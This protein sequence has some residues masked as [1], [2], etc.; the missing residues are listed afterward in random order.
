MFKIKK[1]K[2]L[3]I[4]IILS[5]SFL[6]FSKGELATWL[7]KM[8]NPI[9]LIGNYKEGMVDL[10]KLEIEQTGLNYSSRVST[11]GWEISSTF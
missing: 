10:K 9:I 2:S 8:N 11:Y 5:L 1:I 3:S 7:K 6:T 4:S